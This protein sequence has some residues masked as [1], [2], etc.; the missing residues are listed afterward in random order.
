LLFICLLA[1]VRAGAYANV[2]ALSTTKHEDL[3]VQF[4]AFETVGLFRVTWTGVAEPGW[5]LMAAYHL[6][7][8]LKKRRL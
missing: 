2:E 4:A 3:R 7:T 5:T 8:I 1:A 6:L